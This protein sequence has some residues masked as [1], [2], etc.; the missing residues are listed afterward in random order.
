MLG[1]GCARGA[2]DARW[3]EG[4]ATGRPLAE[5]PELRRRVR[6][7]VAACCPARN[8]SSGVG[9][10]WSTRCSALGAL[11][12]STRGSAL[13]VFGQGS[14]HQ[15]R[16]RRP[17]IRCEAAPWEPPPGSVARGAGAPPWLG[18]SGSCPVE[19]G[20][21]SRPSSGVY[22]RTTWS[23][24]APWLKGSPLE[25]ASACGGGGEGVHFS[26]GWTAR[27]SMVLKGSCGVCNPR[28]NF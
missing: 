4:V 10:A 26:I 1:V 17:R 22:S 14:F 3:S 23:L 19:K 27:P 11:A 15:G 20:L 18:W 6:G 5:G 21:R 13:G 7:Q 28:R 24:A 16:V 9:A 8:G 2:R 12:W 25:S